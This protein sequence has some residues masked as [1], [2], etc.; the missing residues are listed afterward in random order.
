[1]ATPASMSPSL[2]ISTSRFAPRGAP[3]LRAH[4]P[5]L[6]VTAVPR[7]ASLDGTS[8]NP[9]LQ[10]IRRFYELEVP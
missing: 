4:T 9:G 10:G 6:R 1:M 5:T 7:G 2:P 3:S 8:D